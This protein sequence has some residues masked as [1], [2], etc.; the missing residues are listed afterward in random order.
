MLLALLEVEDHVA[1][2]WGRRV[3]CWVASQWLR[4]PDGHSEIRKLGGPG[5]NLGMECVPWLG[6]LRFEGEQVTA[7]CGLLV[8]DCCLTLWNHA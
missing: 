1:I 3:S 2:S 7:N 4:N 5:S 8:S 6:S